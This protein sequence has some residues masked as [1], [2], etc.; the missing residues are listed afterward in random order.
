MHRTYIRK[1]ENAQRAVLLVHGIL[2][3]PNHFRDLLPL[4]PESWSVYNI[5]LDGHGG[6]AE[7]FSRTSMDK[8]KAQVDRQLDDILLTHRQILIIAH[9]MGTLFAIRQAIRRPEPVAGLFLLNVPLAPMLR[10]RTAADCL[11]LALGRP[12]KSASAQAMAADSGVALTPKLWK[13]IGWTPRFWEL[14]EEVKATKKLLPQ[15]HTPTLVFQSRHDELVHLSACK[16]L[17]GHP[18]ITLARLEHSGHFAYAP[19]DTKRLQSA[20]AQQLAALDA[21]SL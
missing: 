2:G 8:W 17:E 6:S 5:L 16:H 14:L 13:Y 9:S 20:L 19:E 1:A 3:T 7:D 4:I 15:L 18:S 11:R 21:L 10:P 12:G